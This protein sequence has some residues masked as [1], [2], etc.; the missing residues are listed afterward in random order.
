MY[1]P[2]SKRC[3]TPYILLG[4]SLFGCMKLEAPIVTVI[5]KIGGDDAVEHLV[6]FEH[7][8]LR[9]MLP[10]IQ[11]EDL[12]GGLRIQEYKAPEPNLAQSYNKSGDESTLDG[13][14]EI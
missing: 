10:E 9:M 5:A 7:V 3:K 12:E 4:H 2:H 14:V 13:F 11:M 8:N 1:C 6:K